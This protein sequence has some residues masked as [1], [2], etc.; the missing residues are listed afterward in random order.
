M[1]TAISEFGIYGGCSLHR[2]IL[3]ELRQ[4]TSKLSLPRLSLGR[5]ETPEFIVG[6]I[7]QPT[8]ITLLGEEILVDAYSPF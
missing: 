1:N 8:A 7:R 5:P 3:E 2:I 6:Q 4:A